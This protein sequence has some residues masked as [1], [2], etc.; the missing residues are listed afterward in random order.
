MKITAR[1]IFIVG[2]RGF[3]IDAV[4]TVGDAADAMRV[5]PELAHYASEYGLTA[6]WLF[7]L[8]KVVRR[9]KKWQ[10]YAA[11]TY[12]FR[13][14]RNRASWLAWAEHCAKTTPIETLKA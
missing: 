9:W 14:S 4:E 13:K 7:A 2:Q 1:E 3:D 12:T 5:I 10:D 11:V 6:E 8:C